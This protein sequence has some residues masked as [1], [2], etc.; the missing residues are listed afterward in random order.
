MFEI[1]DAEK[2]KWNHSVMFWTYHLIEKWTDGKL[3]PGSMCRSSWCSQVRSSCRAVRLS[4]SR[5]SRVSPSRSSSSSR[6]RPSQLDRT[7]CVILTS[8]VAI[9]PV[10]YWCDYWVSSLLSC[11]HKGAA[12]QR[13]GPAGGT[14]G[15]RPDHR[16]PACQCR[17]HCPAAG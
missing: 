7:R 9:W 15:W 1:R 8:W 5:V 16:L 14:D 13:A 4:S 17:W 3:C 6:R 11:G 2:C 12:D 10:Y